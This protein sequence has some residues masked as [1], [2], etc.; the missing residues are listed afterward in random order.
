[1][2]EEINPYQAPT[3]ST[4][5]DPVKDGV[6][7]HIRNVRMRAGLTLFFIA[8]CILREVGIN[9]ISHIRPEWSVASLAEE[10]PGLIVSL[11]VVSIALRILYLFWFMMWIYRSAANAKLLDGEFSDISPGMAVW[12]F[13]IPFFNLI[14]PF[15]AMRKVADVIA[16]VSNRPTAWIGVWWVFWL[17]PSLVVIIGLVVTH[18]LFW[19]HPAIVVASLV[20]TAALIIRLSAAQIRFYRNP[21]LIP[22]L[23][24]NPRR[25]TNAPGIPNGM[26]LPHPKRALRAPVGPATNAPKPVMA[27]MEAPVPQADSRSADWDG[28]L[29]M[30]D[31]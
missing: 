12:S 3:A 1:M 30:E 17:A 4:E 10:T 21:P 22:R 15:L 20:A 11:T 24:G 5:P 7:V 18:L 9:F 23:G 13:F 25:H 31:R 28:G 27:R 29:K 14:G 16:R 2:S 8:L 26:P 19:V 6:A